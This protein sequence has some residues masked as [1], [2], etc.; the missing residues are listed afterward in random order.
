MLHLLAAEPP[1]IVLGICPRGNNRD[2]NI[3]IVSMTYIICRPKPG[4][5]ESDLY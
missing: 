5:R 1:S 4:A 2:D 3:T